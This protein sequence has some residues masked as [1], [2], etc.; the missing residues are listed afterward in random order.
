[1]TWRKLLGYDAAE[2]KA[3]TDAQLLELFGPCL[4]VTR[5][6]QAPRLDTKKS[7]LP[8]NKAKTAAANDILN[9]L[10]FDIEL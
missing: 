6:D 7:T 8:S 3:M 2:L 1:M 5:P 4:K 9:Q 10:G